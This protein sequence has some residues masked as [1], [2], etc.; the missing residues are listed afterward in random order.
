MVF[1]LA[2]FM[3]TNRSDTAVQCVFD[4]A[5]KEG[6]RFLVQAHNFFDVV[7]LVWALHE[8]CEQEFKELNDLLGR[9]V[10]AEFN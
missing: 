5:D 8:G 1:V 9:M 7:L 10:F 3:I 6:L 2:N 4:Y